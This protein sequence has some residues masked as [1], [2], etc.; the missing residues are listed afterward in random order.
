MGQPAGGISLQNAGAGELVIIAYGTGWATARCAALAALGDKVR[1]RVPRLFAVAGSPG[2]H[3]DTY[4]QQNL[5]ALGVPVRRIV[6]EEKTR[7][8]SM[9]ANWH[10]APTTWSPG[11]RP[12]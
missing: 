8:C 3:Y 6:R 7:G 1:S 4:F 12:M 10:P 9:P 5:A 11:S 2:A